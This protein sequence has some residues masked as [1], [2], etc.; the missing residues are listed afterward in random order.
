[1]SAPEAKALPPAPLRTMARMP[2]RPCSR[3]MTLGR[4]AHIRLLMAFLTWGRLRMMRAYV[5]LSSTRISGTWVSMTPPQ[6]TL[7]G[8]RL[9]CAQH[10][11]GSKDRLG[12]EVAH[13][14]GPDGP[15]PRL[16]DVR[17]PVPLIQDAA[18]RG[19]DGG[20]GRAGLQGVLEQHGG[21]KDGRDGV[22]LVL[23]GDVRGASMDGLVQPDTLPQAGRGQEADGAGEHGGL[24]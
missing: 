11:S 1:M 22:G 16:L 21:R 9:S 18:H 23:P 14:A 2:R 4:S 12:D 7:E 10:L 20:R 19:L 8:L 5:S 6:L 17:R 13:A 15:G 24:V 3:R